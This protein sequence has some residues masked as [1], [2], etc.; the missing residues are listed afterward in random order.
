LH[1]SFDK[2]AAYL[3]FPLSRSNILLSS[4]ISTPLVVN[5]RVKY[6]DPEKKY[7]KT[8]WKHKVGDIKY[9]IEEAQ[10]SYP[11]DTFDTAWANHVFKKQL[12]GL[13]S[14]DDKGERCIYRPGKYI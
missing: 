6:L 1:Y 11:D 13:F 9:E 10:E 3:L 8:T 7:L 12:E 5:M 2:Q 4:L 14:L